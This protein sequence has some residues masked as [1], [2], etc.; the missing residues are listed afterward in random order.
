MD[1]SQK[2]ELYDQIQPSQKL[3]DWKKEP[4]ADELMTDYKNASTYHSGQVSKI[5]DWLNLL[6]VQSDKTKIKKGRS[7]VSPKVIRRLAEWRYS[8]LSMP[9]LNEKNLFKVNAT[10]PAHIHAAFQNE[11]ILNNQFNNQINKVKFINNY[12][13]TA[14]NEGTVIV[15]VGWDSQLQTKE[16]EEPIYE[17][18]QAMP[19]EAQMLASLMQQIMQEQQEMGLETADDS[20]TFGSLEPSIQESIKQSTEHGYPILTQDTG[21]TQIIKEDV[22]V[23]NQPEVQ[24]IDNKSLIIDP[25]CDG[26]FAKARFAVYVYQTSISE[27]K[28]QGGYDL[29]SLLNPLGS[30]IVVSDT[31]TASDIINLPDEI[32]NNEHKSVNDVENNNAF[33]FQD[34]ARKRLTAYEYW[35]Y[36]DIDG[37]GVVQGIVATIVN[38]KIIKLERNPFPDGKLPFVVVPYMPVKS[39]V[40]GEP[41]AELVKDNQQIIQAS[42]RA[43]MDIQARSANGQTAIPKGFLDPINL[44]KFRNGDDYEYNLGGMHPAEA[45]YMHTANEVPQTTM[46]LVQQHYAEAE[47]AT[48]IKA[49]QNGIDGNAYGQVVAG[50]SQA[51]TALTQRES[52]ILIRLSQGLQELSNKITAMNCEWLSEEEVVRNLED[53]YIPIRREELYGNFYLNVSVKS[54]SESEGKAQQLTFLMQ[55]LGANT[56]WDIRQMFLLEI[57]RLYNLDNMAQ[58]VKQ[59]QP[60]PDPH[61]QE[62]QRLELEEAQ[63]KIDKLKEEALY[64]RKRSEFIDAQVPNVMADTDL[65]NLDFVEQESGTKHAREVDRIQAQAREQNK[66]KLATE[67]LKGQAA[68]QVAAINTRARQLQAKNKD[69]RKKPSG[70]IPNPERLAVP[71]GLYRADGLGNYIRGDNATNNNQVTN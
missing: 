23:R 16:R 1:K 13:R 12:V 22:L 71:Q 35:G 24:V 56:P 15:R 26:D 37:T 46:A 14:V 47:A 3:T 49:F 33:F 7:G 45:I 58:M 28:Q 2:Q 31:M 29:I 20:P 53:E 66:G 5:N 39:S 67:A 11:L 9:F 64:Y 41:D 48:G 68:E 70:K 4:K 34:K 59:Y 8:S 32:F 55:T 27:L 18:V 65:K 63:A 25:T 50:M 51:I 36:W 6:N 43:I 42:T 44:T 61:Q 69:G 38:N 10:S 62:L 30:N 21:K 19:E 60:Q 57:A 17:Y 40:Y 52:D 54:N